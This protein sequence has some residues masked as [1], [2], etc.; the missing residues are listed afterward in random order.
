MYITFIII[1]NISIH[2]WNR[3]ENRHTKFIL[4][5]NIYTI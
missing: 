3:G 5:T 2:A 1:L 4:A